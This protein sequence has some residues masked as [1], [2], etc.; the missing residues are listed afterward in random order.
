MKKLSSIILASLLC[1]A[2]VDTIILPDD[3]TVDEDFWQTK[4]D[5]SSMVN[6]AYNA[7]SSTDVLTR[8]ILWGGFRGDEYALVKESDTKGSVMDALEEIEGV[9]IQTTNMYATWAS[10]YNVINICNIVLE[11][12]QQVPSIDP[13]YT[14]GD[15]QVHRSQML[16]LRSLCYFYLVRAFRDVP[17]STTAFM[18]SSQDMEMP[19]LAP[20]VVLQNCLRD[21]EEAEANALSPNAY[22]TTQWRRVGWITRDGINALQADICLWLASVHHSK[23]YYQRCVDYCEKIIESKKSQHLIRAGQV[24]E[25]EFPLASA[26]AMFNNVFSTGNAEESIFELQNQSN[27]AVATFFHK[28]KNSN[29]SYGYLRASNIFGETG[30]VYGNQNSRDLRMFNNVYSGTETFDI[31]KMVA[32]N[33]TV[34]AREARPSLSIPFKRNYIIYRLTDIMLM[35]A[36]ALVQL[37]DDDTDLTRLRTAYYMVQAVNTRSIKD[38]A[39][40]DSLKWSM[41]GGTNTKFN[42]KED[43]EKYI[44]LERQRELCFEGK[45]WY[46][47]LRYHY[48]HV[49]GTQYDKTMAQ[50]AQENGSFPD[51]YAD[52]KVLMTQ[53]KGNARSGIQ[54]KM[55]TEPYLYMP[56]PQT[57]I[58][59]S[60]VLVQ[61]P[62]WS[63]GIEYEKSY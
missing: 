54:A 56:I 59:V 51:I 21:L 53:S 31:R 32:N 19:Q 7:M 52:M 13:N 41:I 42:T 55:K 24:E 5:V 33:G 35:R 8:L 17:Y 48:R 16:A 9:N 37:M 18:N 63:S 61:N 34:T 45:R 20:D 30:S 40:S 29:S 26:T 22:S 12:Q 58:N 14:I 11:K 27:S 28:F 6:G 44:M 43:A 50:I 49:E 1:T 10:L 39:K 25:S 46:D 47:L 23:D 3:K 60:P 62:V 2:C 57:D 36:E 4:A 38:D 15:M